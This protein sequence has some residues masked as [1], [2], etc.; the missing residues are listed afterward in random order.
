VSFPPL[1]PHSA[2][3][4][5]RG[6]LQLSRSP[7]AT[8]AWSKR[9]WLVEQPSRWLCASKGHG[10]SGPESN[11][12][13]HRIL[14]HSLH[15][16]RTLGVGQP[17]QPVHSPTI[18]LKV[19][20]Y[21]RETQEASRLQSNTRVPRKVQQQPDACYGRRDGEWQDNSSKYLLRRDLGFRRA[22]M[23]ALRYRKSP[24]TAIFPTPGAR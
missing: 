7:R 18:Q 21:P 19:F 3:F 6:L 11:C 4:D 2:S 10:R 12:A 9:K 22:D 16:H 8:T 23:S 20:R 14:P 15:S 5:I 13:L 17:R 24:A 1:F